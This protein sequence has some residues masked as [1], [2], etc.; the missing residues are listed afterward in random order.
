MEIKGMTF[1]RN[2]KF[3]SWT[4][5]L[6]S[7]PLILFVSLL[8]I[9]YQKTG[10]FQWGE[11]ASMSVVFFLIVSVATVPGLFLHYKYYKR[12]KGK[13][14][15]F[16]PTYFEITQN[17]LTNKIYY[18]DI[19]SIEKHYPVW[20]HR[21]PWSNYGYIKLVLNDNQIFSY[22]CLTHDIISSAILFK[23]KDVVVEDCGELYPL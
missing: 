20:N 21:M 8:I 17:N 16:R 23:N 15:R 13:S 7:F 9:S 5:I 6:F 11:T 2:L 12:D 3:I 10:Y 22:S 1:N 14:L 18:K 4:V 19:S